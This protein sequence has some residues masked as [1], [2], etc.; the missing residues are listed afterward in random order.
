M[1]WFFWAGAGGAARGGGGG[2]GGAG[3][4]ARARAG[5]PAG[6]ARLRPDRPWTGMAAGA[7]SVLRDG[8]G[9]CKRPCPDSAACTA[10]ATDLLQRIRAVRE[11]AA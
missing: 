10:R 3:G 5:A 4:G 11:S 8:R 9:V 7:G 6:A 1:C 2:R